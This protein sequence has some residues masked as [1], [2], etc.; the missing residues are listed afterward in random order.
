MTY[1]VIKK[2]ILMEAVIVIHILL[3]VGIVD[4]KIENEKMMLD[5]MNFTKNKMSEE[6]NETRKI[7]KQKQS[8]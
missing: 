2:I 8:D 6:K 4:T 5:G 7:E 1:M 3:L